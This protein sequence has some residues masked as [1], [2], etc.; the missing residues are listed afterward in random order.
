MKEGAFLS[1]N[2]FLLSQQLP[3][4]WVV[5]TVCSVELSCDVLVLRCASHPTDGRGSTTEATL[6]EWTGKTFNFY[7]SKYSASW[8]V[9]YGTARFVTSAKPVSSS[10]TKFLCP[11]HQLQKVQTSSITAC[12]VEVFPLPQNRAIASSAF[13]E[14]QIRSPHHRPKILDPP[15]RKCPGFTAALAYT[16]R[17]SDLWKG[18]TVTTFLGFGQSPPKIGKRRRKYLW[19]WTPI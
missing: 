5:S 13:T 1:L 4:N 16:G 11:R 19:T 3:N 14:W 2:I 10:K 6:M 17:T 18:H 12:R 9:R 7:V 8:L 15:A